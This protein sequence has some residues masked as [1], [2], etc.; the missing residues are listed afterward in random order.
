MKSTGRGL[1]GVGGGRGTQRGA[2]G[3]EGTGFWNRRWEA[4]TGKETED[5]TWGY[6]TPQGQLL[7]LEIR[8]RPRE[9]VQ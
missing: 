3:R 4:N 1:R 7:I 2:K 9:G 8:Q 5:L 6:K